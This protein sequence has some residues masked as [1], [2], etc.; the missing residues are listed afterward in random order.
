MG[1]KSVETLYSE[2]RFSSVLD[3][4]PLPSLPPSPFSPPNNFDFSISSTAQ[5]THLH[6]IELEGGGRGE[7]DAIKI[8]QMLKYRKAFFVPKRVSSTFVTHCGYSKLHSTP[9][10]AMNL[11][12]VV[13]GIMIMSSLLFVIFV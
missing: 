7:L 4:F 8:E 11:E 5:T 2:T 12:F 6:N 3:T 1:D 13:S 9:N 10:S